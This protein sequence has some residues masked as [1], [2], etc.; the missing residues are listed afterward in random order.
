M[1]LCGSMPARVGAFVGSGVPYFENVMVPEGYDALTCLK[2]LG[3]AMAATGAVALFHVRG[4]T[5]ESARPEILPRGVKALT[6]RDEDLRP[7]ELERPGEGLDLVALGCPHLS[8]EEVA[9]V[10]SAL[11]GRAVRT[12]LWI[13]C[14]RAVAAEAEGRGLKAALD[15]TG[16]RLVRDTCVVVA[17][18][19]DLGLRRVA[20]NSAKAAVYLGMHGAGVVRF[21]SLDEC[22]EA[23]VLGRWRGWEGP[24]RLSG[25]AVVAGEAEGELL[26]TGDPLSFY[27]GVDPETGVVRDPAHELRG[28]CV[29]GKVLA[30]P[31]GKGSTVGSYVIYAL[32]RNGKAPAA[33]LVGRADAIVA[34]GAV[35]ADVPTVDGID[36]SR[37]TT[38]RRAHVR[39]GE[40]DVE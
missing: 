16:A 4:L 25:R 24:V 22:V 27:G 13:C 38:G 31:E 26:V 37:L 30:F 29:A 39:G 2:Q 6:I 8:I 20:V 15:A 1:D 36:V 33:M 12:P 14:S 28:Q 35:I 40:V 11:G 32:R 5:P 21:G 7:A 9:R 17:P 10:A 3:A 19:E 18:L 23:A 34:T